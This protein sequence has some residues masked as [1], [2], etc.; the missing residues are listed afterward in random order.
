MERAEARKLI[1]VLNFKLLRHAGM[2]VTKQS[3]LII[4]ERI[5]FIINLE[6]LET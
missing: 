2:S 1:L 4:V 3:M 5:I 6:N